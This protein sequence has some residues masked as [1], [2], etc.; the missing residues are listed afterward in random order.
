MEHLGFIHYFPIKTSIS[1]GF[2]SHD[3][4]SQ[5]PTCDDGRF[6]L[7]LSM[8]VFDV[9]ALLA[10]LAVTCY[11][12]TGYFP[13]SAM[14]HLLSI[15]ISQNNSKH[16]YSICNYINMHIFLYIRFCIYMYIID[17]E[18]LSYIFVY[19]VI[20][21]ITLA[22]DSTAQSASKRRLMTSSQLVRLWPQ[23]AEAARLVALLVCWRKDSM[24]NWWVVEPYPP[25]KYE[26]VSWDYE[27]PNI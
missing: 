10:R 2:P 20:K 26:F 5:K 22:W 3:S 7:L 11:G 18:N 4:P 23:E 14:H 24:G 17:I 13:A 12:A 19:Y 27:I 8:N 25:E 6:L 21:N 1:R 16:M 9:D 15:S